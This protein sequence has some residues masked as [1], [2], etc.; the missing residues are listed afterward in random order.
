[1]KDHSTDVFG[2]FN[3]IYTFSYRTFSSFVE[4]FYTP[5]T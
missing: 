2:L 1:M 5:P 4:D 3:L